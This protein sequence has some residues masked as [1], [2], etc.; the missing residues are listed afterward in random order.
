MTAA[1]LTSVGGA[2]AAVLGVAFTYWSLRRTARQEQGS[3]NVASWKSLNEALGRDN[4]DLRIR[5][6]QFEAKAAET[7]IEL[8][9]LR[10]E[11][12]ETKERF[13]VVEDELKVTKRRLERVERLGP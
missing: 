12:E 3:E 9:A 7:E 11:L 6:A 13:Q 5:I 1:E 10:D 4:H 2:F 8:H